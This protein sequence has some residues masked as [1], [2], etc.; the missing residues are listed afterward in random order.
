[1]LTQDY[2]QTLITRYPDL[3][4][5]ANDARTALDILR[6]TVRA[7]RKILVCGN[8]GSASD[9]EHIVGE[10]MK[11]YMLKR[12]LP[13]DVR[14]RLRGVFPDEGD[15]LADHL[16]GAIQAIALGSHT[17]LTTA[18]ANDVAPDMIFAQQVYGYSQPGDTLLMLSTSGNSGNVVRAAQVACA[19]GLHTIALTGQSGGKLNSLCDVTIRVPSDRTPDI[20]ERHLPIYHALCEALEAEFFE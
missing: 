4:P 8:G 9:A 13:T 3:T 6:D 7:G 12:P 15:Y 5:C 2:I 17:A 1:M 11:G 18:F 14:E 16:Q 19:M 20:Q 10:L